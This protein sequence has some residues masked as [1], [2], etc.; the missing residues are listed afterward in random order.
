[1]EDLDVCQKVF[2]NAA[3]SLFEI[4]PISM[5]KL[6][7]LIL[8]VWKMVLN[9]TKF[10]VQSWKTDYRNRSLN[11]FVTR[12]TSYFCMMEQPHKLKT[13]AVKVNEI[14][15]SSEVTYQDLRIFKDSMCHS[16]C[17]FIGYQNQKPTDILTE[18]LHFQWKSS[19]RHLSPAPQ[20]T[21]SETLGFFPGC[22]FLLKGPKSKWFTVMIKMINIGD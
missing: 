22:W 18:T 9:F 21:N 10:H 3:E 13:L 14:S 19:I 6:M 20:K 2:V 7:K 11:D 4:F 12:M 8:K 1:M 15:P 17:W 16:F 5:C